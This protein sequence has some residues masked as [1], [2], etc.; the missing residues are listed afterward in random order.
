MPGRRFDLRFHVVADRFEPSMDV[1]AIKDRYYTIA[2]K[3]LLASNEGDPAAVD[4]HPL[5]K[6]PYDAEYERKRKVRSCRL[7]L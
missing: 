1:E 4:G 2:R 5:I 6:H 7:S 3:L